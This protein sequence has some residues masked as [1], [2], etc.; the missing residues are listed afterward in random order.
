MGIHVSEILFTDTD[1]FGD[2]V[3]VASRISSLAESNEICFSNVVFQNIRNREDL[4]IE[5]LGE[6]QLKNVAY[7]VRVF[8]LVI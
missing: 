3:N 8:K 5:D 2:G 4:K 6:Q 1:I 7:D